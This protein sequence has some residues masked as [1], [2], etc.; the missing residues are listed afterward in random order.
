MQAINETHGAFLALS[1]VQQIMTELSGSAT[2]KEK[3]A[4]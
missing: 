1:M 2:G 4:S 3:V